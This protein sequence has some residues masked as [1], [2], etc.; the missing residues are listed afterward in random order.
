MRNFLLILCLAA[1]PAACTLLDDAGGTKSRARTLRTP[2]ERPSRKDPGQGAKTADTVLWCSAV[3]FPDDYDWQQDSAYGNASFELLLY[4]DF[5]PVLALPSGP[6][7]CFSPDP[8]R[9][10]ILSGH[11]YTELITG[12]DTRIGRDGEELFRFDGR[13]YLVGLLE[14]GQDLYTL[15][16]PVHGGGFCFRKNGDLL[17]KR[18]D[19]I[20]YGS[21]SDPSYAPSGALYRDADDIVFCFRAGHTLQEEIYVVRDGKESALRRIKGRVLDV[22]IRNRLPCLLQPDSRECSMSEG[23]IWPGPDGYA[24]TGRFV[25]HLRSYSGW[26]PADG[27]ARARWLCSEE[28]VLYYCPEACFAVSRDAQGHVCW[29]SESGNGRSGQPCHFFTPACAFA[30]GGRLW[31]ALSPRDA[32]LKPQIRIGEQVHTLPLHGYIS[33]LSAEIIPAS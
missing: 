3:R 7:A 16:R 23:R 33:S 15:W 30:L 32:W 4:R 24:V 13:E 20:P 28:A 14:D 19:G 17:L 11:L 8:D 2:G 22:R 31:L 1:L 26:M 9:H 25:E 29:Y 18:S 5:S 12:G 6:Q 21:L 10:H 27:S